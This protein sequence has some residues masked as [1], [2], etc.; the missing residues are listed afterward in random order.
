MKKIL[1]L[2]VMFAALGGGAKAQVQFSFGPGVGF[3]YA[4]HSWTDSDQT[5]GGFGALVTS[6]FDMQFSRNLGILVWL[7]FYSDMSTKIFD[8]YVED[9]C[10]INYFSLA[11]TLKFCIPRSPFYLFGGP[12]FGVKTIGK[13]LDYGDFNGFEG[14]YE[15][16]EILDMQARID[17]RLGAG[18]EFFLSKKLTLTP[19]AAF[20]VGMNEVVAGTGWQINTVQ[21]GLTLRFNC[22]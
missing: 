7:D 13:F 1:I 22:F 5:F 16:K 17:V 6:Q 3:N 20:N 18:Y 12:G 15:E 21:A 4:V 14:F 8:G 9:K 10:K 19:F 2:M 11:P